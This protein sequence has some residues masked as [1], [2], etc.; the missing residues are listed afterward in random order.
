M[1][2][3][4]LINENRIAEVTNKLQ[5]LGIE[6]DIDVLATKEGGLKD[7]LRL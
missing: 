4:L 1:K 7:I 5:E 2:V 3:K 6:I